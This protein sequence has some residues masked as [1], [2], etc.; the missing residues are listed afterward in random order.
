MAASTTSFPNPDLAEIERRH[1][2]H[3]WFGFFLAT[4]GVA[5]LAIVA[6]SVA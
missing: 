6:L 1:R 3:G 4:L 2:L 5:A